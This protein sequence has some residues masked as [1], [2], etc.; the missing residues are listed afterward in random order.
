MKDGIIDLKEKGEISWEEFVRRFTRD[1]T[2]LNYCDPIK[3][4]PLKLLEEKTT[5][6][7]HSIPE[8]KVNHSLTFLQ[9]MTGKN[10]ICAK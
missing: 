6:M 4:Q 10:L 1:N 2:K 7:K 9:C 3:R 8:M 5:N